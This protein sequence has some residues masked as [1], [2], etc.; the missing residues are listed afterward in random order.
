MKNIY[1]NFY[2]KIIFNASALLEWND[3]NAVE[4]SE[5]KGKICQQHK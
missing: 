4:L 3:Y 2:R 1:H 5:N